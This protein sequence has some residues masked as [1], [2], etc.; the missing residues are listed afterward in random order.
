MK[1]FISKIF[2]FSIF[3]FGSLFGLFLLE[4]GTADPFYQRVVGGEKKS[5][6][7]GTSKAAQGIVPTV[8]NEKLE[9]DGEKKL[10]NFS[11]TTIHSPFGESYNAAIHKKIDKD[12]KDGV[13]IV[14]V[15]PW[16]LSS[17][18]K[19][20]NDR[21]MMPDNKLFLG[22]LSSFSPVV[23][24]EYLLRFYINPYYEIP[25]RYF[26]ENSMHLKEDGWLKATPSI[27]EERYDRFYK[28]KIK[29]YEVRANRVKSSDYRIKS[30]TSLLDFLNEKGDVYVVVL[31]VD[32]NIYAIEKSIC[33]DAMSNI[34]QLCNSKGIPFKDFNKSD[35]NYDFVDGVHLN[36]KSASLFSEDL[37]IW[38]M[39]VNSTNNQALSKD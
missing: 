32:K 7:I 4:N 37:A 5:M 21:S 15:D 26:V 13:F 27:A 38:M 25:L 31:P 11:F 6:V 30:F 18:K 34:K 2:V 36:Y 17:S 3:P 22:K 16:S 28:S 10:Y 1:R 33:P 12:S 9:L 29:E 39:E 14:T 23:N 8:I 35:T 24:L 20:P 19:D